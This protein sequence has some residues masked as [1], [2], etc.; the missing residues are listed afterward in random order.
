MTSPRVTLVDPISIDILSPTSR[1]ATHMW[2]VAAR[3]A[4]TS[5]RGVTADLA[6]RV[7]RA[8]RT[9]PRDHARLLEGFV[10]YPAGA[11]ARIAWCRNGEGDKLVAIDHRAA[12][13]VGNGADIR[14]D[15]C[16]RVDDGI[17]AIV[18]IDEERCETVSPGPGDNRRH[19]ACKRRHIETIASA[20]IEQ[21]DCTSPRETR[22]GD[23]IVGM[24]INGRRFCPAG[25]GSTKPTDGRRRSCG[26]V[27]RVRRAYSCRASTRIGSST[28]ACRHSAKKS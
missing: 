2:H 1:I 27:Q 18:N 3:C 7:P 14:G 25:S 5:A 28:S 12:R 8:R 11:L 22:H 15:I 13:S 23:R 19:R 26:V 6:T 10:R 4:C 16:R 24:A 9:T 21:S 20:G 17:S